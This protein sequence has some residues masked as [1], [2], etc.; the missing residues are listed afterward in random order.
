M[1]KSSLIFTYLPP[2]ARLSSNSLHLSN[3]QRPAEINCLTRKNKYNRQYHKQR[4][5][6][7]HWPKYRCTIRTCY[8]ATMLPQPKSTSEVLL[9][10]PTFTTPAKLLPPLCFLG[11]AYFQSLKPGTTALQVPLGFLQP[12]H[13]HCGYPAFGNADILAAYIPDVKRNTETCDSFFEENASIS[14]VVFLVEDLQIL[15]RL[16]GSSLAQN[17][18]KL[19]K[20]FNN[21][22][23][24][25]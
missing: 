11:V 2:G 4:V 13:L 1:A 24:S 17:I 15:N 23:P 14:L 20:C 25:C 3:H 9:Q 10:T 8:N 16:P 5:Q 22:W 7:I 6:Q 18:L 19:R 12:K 21:L